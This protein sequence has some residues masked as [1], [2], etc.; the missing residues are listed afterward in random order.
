M[1]AWGE[2]WGA[3]WGDAFGE[4]DTPVPD[5]AAPGAGGG[6]SLQ[7]RSHKKVHDEINEYFDLRTAAQ[8]ELVVDVIAK[9]AESA[10][11]DADS[12]AA[13]SGIAALLDEQRNAELRALL[14]I[15]QDEDDAEAVLTM[16]ELA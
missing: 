13:R 5:V 15:V 8:E 4:G 10:V 2:S 1:N 11:S 16:L 6:G 12:R 3:A 14:A 9:A 7:H